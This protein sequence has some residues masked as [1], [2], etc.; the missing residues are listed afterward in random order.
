MGVQL[1][2][3]GELRKPDDFTDTLNAA[4]VAG[5]E[6]SS[7]DMTDFWQGILSQIKR[8]IWADSAGNWHDNPG[9]LS[10]N[11]GSLAVLAARAKLEDKLALHYRLQVAD[12]TPPAAAYASEVLTCSAQPG[13]TETVV[14]N[15]KTYT[16]QTVLTDVDGNVLIG[17]DLAE[18]LANLKAAINLEAGAGTKYATSTTL[19][20]TITATSDATTL[21]ATAKK[22]GTAGNALTVTE[23]LANGAWGAGTLSGGA[24]DVVALTG[25]NKPDKVIAIANTQRGAVVAQLAGAI[26]SA[27]LTENSGSNPLRP[28]NFVGIFDG[29]TGDPVM[30]QDGR[31]I[32]GLL[33]VGSAATDGNAF[34]D[35]GNDQ[36]QI[37]FVVAN[38]TFDDLEIADGSNIGA[39]N[40]VY[41]FSNRNDLQATVEEGF[42]GDLDSADP[43]AGVTISLDAAYNG[44]NLVDVDALDV[45]WRLADTLEF[46]IRKAGGNPLMRVVRDDGGTDLIQ[47]G[48]DVDLFDVDAADSNFAQGVAVDTSDQTINLGKTAV[49]VIDSVSIELRATTGN[50][51]ISAPAGDVQFRTVLETTALPLDD[52]TAGKISTLFSQTFASVSAAI[53]Y[54]GEHGGVDLSLAQWVSATSYSQGTNIP[55]VTLDL[56]AFSGDW[57]TIAGVNLF[58][59]LNGRLLRGGNATPGQE[60][61]WCPGTT[62]ASG[63]VKMQMAKPILT[64]DVILTL[65][66]KE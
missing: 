49:G 36:G 55:A 11:D 9:N 58:L 19:H 65:A 35:S 2:R 60:N 28:K 51:E 39:V 22:A 63:D 24:G 43:Q 41:T 48:S 26:G 1:V 56:T 54:A 20:P 7:V 13:N 50:A 31:R 47:I 52:A 33:Q 42:R 21:T 16:F 27:D 4:A 15:G 38:V 53:K 18:S 23:T 17:I 62:P 40:I 61:D 32:W 5:V 66:L 57:N 10:G 59:F 34:G 3:N 29:D 14:L 45:D 44:G 12:V 37:T 46:I 30:D 25:A 8:L 6:G 64:G